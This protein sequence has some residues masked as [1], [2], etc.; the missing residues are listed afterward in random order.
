MKSLTLEQHPFLQLLV[1][2][3]RI[4]LGT[5]LAYVTIF[6]SAMLLSMVVRFGAIP[7][8]V[9]LHEF[10]AN[11]QQIW[12]STPS[13][14]DAWDLMQHEPWIEIGYKNPDYFNIAE[15]SFILVPMRLPILLLSGAILGVVLMLVR[16]MRSHCSL[17]KRAIVT[18]SAGIGSALLALANATLTWVVC[19]A[20]P[21][22]VVMLAMLGLSTSL[23]LKLEP[24]GN[25]L[26]IAGLALGL[27]SVCILWHQ[28]SFRIPLNNPVARTV[29]LKQE[30]DEEP[31]IAP[32]KREI[33][34]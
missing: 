9:T 3:W 16:Q 20:T 7:N 28:L 27:I 5:A 19:C 11:M 17:G 26:M 18:S 13:L 15:W 2:H 30:P 10:V 4:W 32:N 12:V 34:L 8:Y 14:N 31:E 29:V 24:L 6:Y 1:R 22:W 25:D 21:N 23:S 33:A